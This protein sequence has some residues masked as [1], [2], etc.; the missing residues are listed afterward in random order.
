MRAASLAVLL[1]VPL[2]GCCSFARFFCGPDRTPWISVD[3]TTPEAA[4]R[5]L[6]EALRRDE[7]EVVYLSLSNDY[8]SRLELNSMT[9]QLAWPRILAQNPGLHVAG[10]ANVP[11]AQRHGPDRASLRLDVE[12][13]AV[14]L[15][16]VRQAKWE[17]RWRRADGS[18]AEPG[19]PVQSLAGFVTSNLD[20]DDDTRNRLTFAPLSIDAAL[21]P[22]DSY[23]PVPLE[24]IESA[25]FA[26]TWKV[27]D[28]RLVR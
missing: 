18:L 14:E 12:G 17:V 2:S 4:A 15:Q 26:C 1:L 6:F 23:R 28:V 10:Y 3:Y 7:P 25:G 16:L 5:T 8:R 11:T 21:Q 13:H 19:A 24:A 27:A 9:M 20:P 22:D